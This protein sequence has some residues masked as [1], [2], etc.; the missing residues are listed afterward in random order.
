M[1]FKKV[2]ISAFRIF[3]DQDRGEFDF[4]NTDGEAVDF[5]SIYAPNGFGKTSFY[6]AVEWCVTNNVQRF[7]QNEVLT[8]ESLSSLGE[9]SEEGKVRLL[10]NT[11][12]ADSVVP[13]VKIETDTGQLSRELRVHGNAR[14]DIAAKA[15]FEKGDFRQVILSQE[16]ISSFLK[17]SD[18]EHRYRIFMQNPAL[19][20]LA[21]YYKQVAALGPATK[22]HI[23][24]LQK[25]IHEKQA[26]IIILDE[27]DLLEAV[28]TLI[29]DLQKKGERH[30]Q[31]ALSASPKDVLDF[32]NHITDRVA[33]LTAAQDRGGVYLRSID[34][35]KSALSIHFESIARRQDVVNAIL[36][37]RQV[38][39]KFGQ[40]QAHENDKNTKEGLRNVAAKEREELEKLLL[41]YNEYERVKTI[42][43][44]K[45]IE[46]NQSKAALNNAERLLSQISLNEQELLARLSGI[47][48]AISSLETS[49][50][51]LP[52]LTKDLQGTENGL[53]QTENEIRRLND[54]IASH[55][56]V[57]E[58][59][60]RNQIP[61]LEA[62]IY[63]NDRNFSDIHITSLADLAGDFA[64][65]V[66]KNKQLNGL[67]QQLVTTENNI[68]AHNEFGTTLR[69]FIQQGLVIA[70]EQK[71]GTCPLCTSVF[72]SYET[73]VDK[74]LHN[75]YLSL[76]TQELMQLLSSAQQKLNDG[77]K[78]IT[79]I[80]KSLTDACDKAIQNQQ[81]VGEDAQR[82]I[83]S[84]EI[85][86]T[87]HEQFNRNYRATFNAIQA[88]LTGLSL[89]DYAQ[90][91]HTEKKVT[92]TS[93]EKISLELQD[94]ERQI[95][96]YKDEQNS[97]NSKIA[98][99]EKDITSQS[100]N[101]DFISVLTWFKSNLPTTAVSKAALETKMMEISSNINAIFE[102]SKDIQSAI[103]ALQNELA[104][105]NQQRVIDIL[106]AS[107]D[108]RVELSSAILAFESF[109][110]RSFSFN[111]E[112]A[113]IELLS[114][115][116]Q[117]LEQSQKAT[118]DGNE[119]L[120]TEYRKLQEYNKNLMPFLQ[121]EKAKLE[122]R[123]LN[124]DVEE[125]ETIVLPY[126]EKERKSLQQFLEK[127][128][129]AYF[130]TTLI[131]QIYKKIDPHPDFKEVKF[132]SDFESENPR[133]DVFVTNSNDEQMLIPNLYFSTAQINILSLSIFLAS[134][135]NS[136]NYD[137]IFVDDPIQSMDSINVLS[138]IDLIRGIVAN[139][140][141]QIILSTHDSNFHNLLKKKIPQE[142][143]KSKFIEFET[144]GK[145][146]VD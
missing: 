101:E 4:T 79:D 20:E 77:Q 91:L 29:I 14:N 85:K 18:G 12:V 123:Q 130:Y 115:H 2:E 70:N 135:L 92:E 15:S 56:T 97:A 128:I 53:Q 65:L 103:D 114:N 80:V 52:D 93:K 42:I 64:L 50:N 105:Y 76:R 102:Q 41:Q 54:E 8:K 9:I 140:K 16:W 88:I 89:N 108:E 99:I 112:N 133:L 126:V 78:D 22:S 143:F 87:E 73:L 94:A 21:D 138:T 100:L 57:F 46:K 146:K 67:K 131:N 110:L 95:K 13:F 59:S 82:A 142:H 127:Q 113:S 74:I 35:G 141:K 96:L 48:E 1:K 28:N 47:N 71:T 31:V 19:V 145:V 61:Y 10:K 25:A 55:R 49:I 134:A 129:E 81:R 45:S 58:E 98:A 63:L 43:E 40:L 121:S 136:S 119:A 111:A 84:L 38:L 86:R 62:I 7:W 120:I 90:K 33:D 125:L 122:I 116:L 24:V 118:I 39:I 27:G 44:Q 109:F 107:E 137:C 106:Q 117:A 60:E 66:E 6:D 75:N 37:N 124:K 144:F 26:A 139:Q 51:N 32:N 132:I 72:D 30:S 69:D 3:T 34:E 68:Q 83:Q 17:E 104:I 5:V 23:A 11:K 36:Q